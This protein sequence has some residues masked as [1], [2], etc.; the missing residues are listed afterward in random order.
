MTALDHRLRIRTLPSSPH[1][2][3]AFLAAASTLAAG[4]WA[5]PRLTANDDQD[6]PALIAITLDLEMSR[7]YPTK[8][9]LHWDYEK[10]NLNAETKAYS[11]EAARRVKQHG[12]VIHFFAVGQVFEQENID[13]MKDL[14]AAGHPI[15]NHTYDHV[16]VL[17]EKLEDIQFRF[18]RAPWLIEGKTPAEV[19]HD[20]IQLCTTA[21]KIRLGKNPDGFRT[22]GGFRTGLHGREDIQ[23]LLLGQGFDWVSCLYPAHRYE[24]ENGRISAGVLDSII[25]AQSAAQPFV[26]PTG[27]VD[28]P[29]SPISDVGAFRSAGWD[30]PAFL[31]AVRRGVTWAIDHRAVFDFLAHPSCLYVTDPKFQTIELICD[32]VH[33]AGDRAQLV[34]LGAIAKRA[35]TN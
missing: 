7:Q 26:Y 11:I 12:G 29:M 10:G 28:V 25:E 33:Q 30:L 16:Y 6:Q 3:R 5:A 17:A 31:E 9:Q 14:A 22:P 18:K 1:S 13:W 35:K 32:L 20:N 34:D 4:V 21:M 23:Q 27:L 2:R 15:G 19:I 8:D 24:F